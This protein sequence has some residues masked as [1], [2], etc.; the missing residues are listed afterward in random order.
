MKLITGI[1]CCWKSCCWYPRI[2]GLL[3][4]STRWR[5]SSPSSWNCWTADKGNSG[6]HIPPNLWPPNSPDLNPVDYKIWG[7]MQEKVYRT[8]IRDIEELR[9]R[10]VNACM[11]W[12][13]SAGY[14]CCYWPMPRSSWNL[15]WG[16]RQT[17]FEHAL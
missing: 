12:I 1:V 10:I 14:R 17:H 11:G 6:F 8:K 9:A 2:F 13:W 3:H 7:L 16:R 4:I 5:S 15:C